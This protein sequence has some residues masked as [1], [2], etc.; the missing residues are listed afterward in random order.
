MG[1][2]TSRMT[3][4]DERKERFILVGVK[5]S[6]RDDTEN[7]LKELG[8]LVEAAGAEACDVLIQ[9]LPHP[10][11]GTY[12]GS[13]KLTELSALIASYDADGIVCD[14]ELSPA[15]LQNLTQELSCKVCDRT[16][17][18]LDLFAAH[19]GSREGK[20]QVELAQQQYRA[21]RLTGLGKSLSRLG[22]GIGTR[23]PGEKK[24]EI[25][26]RQVR[27]RIS[28]LKKELD[29]VKRHREVT[30]SRR[31]NT[32]VVTAAIV[33]Y[34]N[35]GKSSLLNALTGADILAK[36]QLFATL[37]P[38]TR[39]FRTEDGQTVLLTDTG[40]FIRKLPHHLVDAF[41]STLE[42]AARADILIHVADA[43]DADRE[44]RR[45]VVY[46][47]LQSLG[48]GHQP[49]IT[50][51]NKQ[52]RLREKL[53]GDTLTDEERMLL[54]EGYRDTRADVILPCSVK[55]GEGLSDVKKALAGYVSAL[56]RRPGV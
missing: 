28:R 40:G 15:Q 33:G 14:D 27:E 47:T 29:E 30:R 13:G 45:E 5:T 42:E 53:A 25:D 20:L 1:K 37:D 49:V 4:T 48:A 36:D 17:I 35:A 24:L 32:G 9:S 46:E 26:R 51:L 52:D 56:S 38:T 19:A 12:I 23:G 3:D 50:V 22:G 31:E 21:A 39:R 7:S 54:T 10:H 11:P 16:L 43:A 55:T 8:A 18:I 44:E 41:R 2:S 6:P 34:T